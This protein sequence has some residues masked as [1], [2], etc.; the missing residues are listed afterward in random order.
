M[1]P[2][3]KISRR[4]FIQEANCAA[5]G[6]ISLFSSLLSLRL[7]AGAVSATSA[8]PDYK[9]LVCL[10]LNGGND[11]FNMLVPRQADAHREYV[12]ARGGLYTEAADSGGI[13]LPVSELL[14]I[15]STR[16]PFA[17]FGIHPDLPFLQKLYNEGN[18]A[19]VAN[20][21]TLVEPTSLSQYRNR[22]VRLPAGLFSHSDEQVHWQ[23]L[24]PQV[25]GTGPKGWAGRMAERMAQANQNSAIAMNI[26]LSGNN[27]LQTGYGSIP[28]IT[29]FTGAVSLNCDDGDPFT[30]TAV[31][32]LLSQHYQNLYQQTLS[33][34]TRNAIEASMAFK[35][36]VDPVQTSV[37]FPNNATANRLAM[38]ARIMRA[39]S[40]LGMERQIFFISRGGWD[41]H[42]DMIARQSSLFGEI[43]EALEAFWTELGA[44]GLQDKVVLYTA[45]DFA[46]TLSSNGSGSDHAWG[47]NHF[48]VSGAAQGGQ[49]FGQYPSLLGGS[50][51]DIGR[52]RVLP[53]TSVD[54]YTAELASWFGVPPEELSTIIPNATRFFDPLSNPY[55]LGI[56]NPSLGL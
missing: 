37:R 40:G 18:A 51:Y 5:V 8:F 11:S 20:V 14:P 56:L 54:A 36:A 50:D 35:S 4:R 34:S 13:A 2:P 44:M 48:I 30:H 3:R 43:N 6:T 12:T 39:R 28:Y 23:T 1:N 25:R 19:F 46:R 7:T 32:S 33:Q 9:A 47:G 49:I 21:G 45:S 10:F 52:G 24:V 55:P 16:Q 29:D 26:S 31:D 17:E 15:E 27:V 22:S 42:S 41:H 38:I 53:T